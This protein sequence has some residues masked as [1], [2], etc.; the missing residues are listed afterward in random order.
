MNREK[1]IGELKELMCNADWHRQYFAERSRKY[2][3]IDFWIKSSIGFVS[4]TG[5][6]LV[7]NSKFG[8]FGGIIAGFGAFLIANVLPNFKW[9]SIV[10][11][12]K[13]E[14]EEW[15]RIHQGYEA[16]LRNAEI[17]DKDEILI[18]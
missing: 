10:N 6:V 15:T 1:F 5:A 16:L 7:G 9:D 4:L 17:S 11:G 18:Q 13:E 14:Q 2:H 8:S 3:R 12:F